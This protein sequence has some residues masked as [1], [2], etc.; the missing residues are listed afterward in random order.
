MS[1]VYRSIP[2][3]LKVGMHADSIIFKSRAGG[4]ERSSWAVSS[5]GEDI[6]GIP[7]GGPDSPS[8]GTLV[9]ERYSRDLLRDAIRL[10]LFPLAVNYEPTDRDDNLMK[11]VEI[12]GQSAWDALVVPVLVK[13]GI[14]VD[15]GATGP[16]APAGLG[17]PTQAGGAIDAPGT[18]PTDGGLISRSPELPP[19]NE[20]QRAIVRDVTVEATRKILEGLRELL[21]EGDT[22]LTTVDGMLGRLT[23]GGKLRRIDWFSL[24]ALL[25]SIPE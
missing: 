22:S 13:A 18:G 11:L 25:G 5:L 1:T 23:S 6:F 10:G 15:T 19:G 21:P 20:T 4:T 14:S 9:G 2:V 12:N 17:M 8:A 7:L 3:W 24:A 16:K